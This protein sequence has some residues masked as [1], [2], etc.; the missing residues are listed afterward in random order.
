M[1]SLASRAGITAVLGPTNTG[2]THYA[3]ERMLGYRTGVIGLPLRL[4]AREVYDRIVAIRGPSVVALVTGEERIVPPR[5]QYWVC[6]VEAM[7]EGMGPDFLAID[8]IQLCADPER[9][10]VFTDR[11]L[12]ARGTHETLF[13]GSDTMRQ[14]I[15]AL[16]PGVQFMRRERMS[17]LSYAGS[18]KISRMPARSAIVGFSVENVYAVAELIRRQKGGAAVVMG[19][20]S[21]RTR[22]AQVALYQN[23]DVD[24]LVATDAIGMGLNLDINHVAFSSLSKFDG[25]RMRNLAPNELAQIAGRAGRGMSDGSFGV[26]GEA[27]PLDDE[28]AQAIMDHRFTPIRKLQWRN[29]ALNFGSVAGLIGSLEQGP[30]DEL[31]IRAREADDLM[32]LK[33][34]SESAEVQARTGTATAVKLLWDVCR[35][36]DFRGISHAEHAGL[37]E[38]IFGFLHEGGAIP[39]DWIARQIRRIDRDDGD[40]DALS[41]RLAYIRTWTYVAQRSGWTQDESHWRGETRAV[42][43]RLSDALHARLTQR[44]VDRRTSVLLRRLKQKEA[45]LAEVNDKGEVTVEGEFVG[46]L[47]GFRFRRDKDAQGQE[48]KTIHQASV[49]ALVPHFHLRADRFYNAPDTEIDFTEQGGLMWGSDAVGRLAPGSDP[50]KPQVVAFVDDEAGPEVAQKVERRLQH[51][52][53]RKIAALFEPLLNLQRDE[54]LSGMARGFAFRMIESFGILPRAEVADE[55]KSLDQEA[56]GALRKHGLRFGQFTIFMPLILKPA[57][58]RLRLVLWSLSK[59]LQEFPEAP[60]PGLV[61]VPVAAGSVDGYHAMAGYRAAGER[62]IRIDMLERLADMLRVEDSRKG[63]E[64]KADMLSITGMTLDQFADLMQGL[65][66]RAEKDERAKVKPAPEAETAKESNTEAGEADGAAAADAQP[67]AVTGDADMAPPEAE[68]APVADAQPAPEATPEPEA[69]PEPVVVA[70][71]E[72]PVAEVVPEAEAAPGAPAQEAS[73]DEAAEMEVFYTFTWARQRPAGRPQQ[74]GRKRPE[75][76]QAPRGRQGGK[77]KPGGKPRGEGGKRDSGAKSFESR[78]PRKDKDRI[79]PDNPF[80]AALM[81]L[82]DKT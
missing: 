81:G 22:N 67:A 55:V 25:R 49:Q 54:T 50:L 56:R 26:T 73:A 31:L 44:F 42:E 19:A 13:L 9:G 23:G 52:I 82:R 2:K 12:R 1:T 60:P 24:Y 71:A 59:G 63:F 11:L 72:T 74:G 66:Y 64:A 21:P 65:G 15:A 69:S 18:K 5:T 29:A 79:D 61:T 53:D 36:P 39:D 27:P 32:A 58:T 45:L 62:A 70:A 4:L 14:T 40:I 47:E 51:F 33:S 28:V 43:D 48:A 80:A 75:G 30:Q 76:G 77:G 37:L 68:A 17:H 35:V 16:V 41:K 6:T 46:R 10:H 8:E 78:P 34:L 38:R 57:P 3:I 7:P 20:L